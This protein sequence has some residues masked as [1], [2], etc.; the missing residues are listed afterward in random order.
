MKTCRILIP[1]CAAIFISCGTENSADKNLADSSKESVSY[2]ITFNASWD[3]KT[4]PDSF[5]SNPHFSPMIG[6]SHHLSGSLFKK[7]DLA[8]P[9]MKLMAE[10][11]A[12]SLLEE[13][14]KSQIDN[15]AGYKVLKG[16]VFDSPGQDSL[17]AT[18]T[19]DF[20]Y[21]TLT[22]MI[23]PSPDWFVGVSSLNLLENGVWAKEKVV[24]LFA[25]DAGTDSGS[26]YTSE[27]EETSPRQPI[28]MI[29]SG[30]FSSLVPVGR[31]TF[32]L[33]E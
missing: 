18:L 3:S 27:N 29:N 26:D 4:H 10:T 9:G 14:A 31:F 25:Y 23:A 15:G 20:S 24:E 32:T 6:M 28:T 19:K 16:R 13:E 21:I 5:P 30:P 22:S 1:F 2:T 11:G 8:S 12:T 7:G 33:K 17:L